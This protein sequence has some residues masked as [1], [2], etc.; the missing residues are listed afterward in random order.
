LLLAFIVSFNL[1][2]LEVTCLAPMTS[3]HVMSFSRSWHDH[4]R[5]PKINYT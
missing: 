5:D 3:N 2:L 1:N 4:R